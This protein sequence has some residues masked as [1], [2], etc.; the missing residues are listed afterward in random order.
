MEKVTTLIQNLKLWMQ[1]AGPV[2]DM[3]VIGFAVLV[4]LV[5]MDLFIGNR[6]RVKATSLIGIW[7]ESFANWY[8]LRKNIAKAKSLH[9]ATRKQYWV[10]P[11]AN[12]YHIINNRQRKK[13]NN[14][15]RKYK[16]V[17]NINDLLNMAVYHTR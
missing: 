11:M 15:L 16:M 2:W 14:L 17:I 4:F 7:F 3:F 1:S 10:V 9:I 5:W 12:N 8:S 13:I 6:I